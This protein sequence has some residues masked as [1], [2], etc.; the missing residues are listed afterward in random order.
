MQELTAIKVEEEKE[1]ERLRQ[2]ELFFKYQL[3]S[4]V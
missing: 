4:L 2:R 1:L 3:E